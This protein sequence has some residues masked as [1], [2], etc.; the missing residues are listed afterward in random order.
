MGDIREFWLAVVIYVVSSITIY[1]I[2]S[3]TPWLNPSPVLQ[4]V[5]VLGGGIV[6]TAAIIFGW[7]GVVKL[8]N[9]RKT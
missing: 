5:A 3:M 8:C 9:K 6:L 1:V 7:A 4:V 2:L